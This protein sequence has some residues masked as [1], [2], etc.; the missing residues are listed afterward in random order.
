MACEKYRD[1]LT[2]HLDG[3]LDEV[4]EAEF[5]RHLEGCERCRKEL[6]NLQ[7]LKEV[8]R[9]MRLIKPS[10]EIWDR[11][12]T[13]IYNR[14]ERSAAWV[15]L[16]IGA[17]IL[18]ILGVYHLCAGF[19]AD[20]HVGIWAKIGAGALIV[21]G[22]TLFVSICRERIATYRVDPYREVKR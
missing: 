14:I 2:A 19:F 7:K 10:D 20:P 15:F 9:S 12:W 17:I 13:Y 5:S 21:G 11:H 8:S 16:S 3:E 18:G 22:V 6:A 4:Q 1:L